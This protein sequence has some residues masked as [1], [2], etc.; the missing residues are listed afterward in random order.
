MVQLWE[1]AQKGE[2]EK[3]LS[4]ATS[5]Q[6]ETQGIGAYYS[7]GERERALRREGGEERER[8]GS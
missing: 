7:S 4:F 2:R 6:G 5:G 1:G 8:G 3:G